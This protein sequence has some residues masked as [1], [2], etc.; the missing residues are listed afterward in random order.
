[1]KNKW[2]SFVI[3]TVLTLSVL[4]SFTFGAYA[5]S[6]SADSDRA[7]LSSHV[8]NVIHLIYDEPLSNND[9]IIIGSEIQEYF[10]IDGCL[11]E[12]DLNAYPIIINNQIIGIIKVSRDTNNTISQVSI[13]REYAYELQTALSNKS[14]LPFV[15]LH[16]DSGVY[17]KFSSCEE[18]D[19]IKAFSEDSEKKIALRSAEFEH[20]KLTQRYAVTYEEPFVT[21]AANTYRQLSVTRVANASPSC[22][23]G[24]ICWA[25]CI[26]MLSNY[27]LNTSFSAMNVHD[28][29][30]C[31]PT[32]TNYHDTHRDYI[33]ELG[34]TV[35]G[36]YNGSSSKAFSFDSVRYWIDRNILMHVDL[37]GGIAHNVLCHGYYSSAQSATYCYLMDPNYGSVLCSIPETA[38]SAISIVLRNTTYSVH[39]YIAVSG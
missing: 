37:Q 39:C 18:F 4:F 19:Q 26:A 33:R 5:Q 1:M 10:V 25:A 31:V 35:L 3:S 20:T 16:T 15:I 27:Y 11:Q 6:I 38:S 8:L 17:I 12:S 28:Y 23:S 2:V 34:M 13:G 36:T 32:G 29:V 14:N 9:E 30:G 7:I 22:C 24:G 21:A